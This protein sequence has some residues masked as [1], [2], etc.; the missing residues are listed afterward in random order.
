MQALKQAILYSLKPH[1]LGLCGPQCVD[2]SKGI[3]R[4]YFLGEDIP[5]DEIRELL[6][7]FT[8][9]YYYL[10]LIAQANNID[11]YF[12]AKVIEAYWLGNS[13][14][15]NVRTQ[16]LKNMILEKFTRPDLLTPEQAKVIVDKIPDKVVAHHSFH[17]FFVGSITGRIEITEDLKDTCKTSWGEVIEIIKDKVLIKTQNLFP[18]EDVETKIDWDK[19][20]TPD[21]KPGDLVSFHW[22][23]IS[24]I[25]DQD[26]LNNLKKYTLINFKALK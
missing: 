26:K 8:G 25:L 22:S 10:E 11:D 14:L 19:K 1:E 21:L 17:V 23:R 20:F 9:A 15:D 13:L 12:D 18:E 2:D 4:R 3:L 24:E 16:D 5:E 7:Q 6:K